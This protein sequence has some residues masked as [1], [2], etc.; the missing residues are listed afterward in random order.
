MI[1]QSCQDTKMN[2]EQYIKSAQWDKKRAERLEIDGHRCAICH[3][4]ERLSVH[5]LHYETL[6]AEDA[7]HDLITLCPNHHQLFDGLERW[8]R[9]SLRK[10][11][12]TPMESVV[13]IRQEITYGMANG[14][15][16]IDFYDNAV[17]AQRT[18]GGP[19]QQVGQIDETDFIQEGQNRR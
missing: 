14:E 17:N 9:Y 18:D 1:H 8:R 3:A 6:T 7:R 10:R 5:H 13:S 2:Y 15:L 19:A 11:E 12:V 4:T 16:Q